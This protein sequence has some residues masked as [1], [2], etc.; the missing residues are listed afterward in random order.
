MAAA[1]SHEC[2]CG[3]AAAKVCKGCGR[4]WYCSK[5][6]Q[7]TDWPKH[8]V[9]CRAWKKMQKVSARRAS[10]ACMDLE[11]HP[12]FGLECV[13]CMDTCGPPYPIP[14]GCAC[15][16]IENKIG[17]HLDCLFKSAQAASGRL[18]GNAEPYH[19][20]SVCKKCFQG[21]AHEFL[22]VERAAVAKAAVEKQRTA[23]TVSEYESALY[24]LR[25]C[26]QYNPECSTYHS[27]AKTDLIG[28]AK[29]KGLSAGSLPH[30]IENANEKI[31]TGRGDEG[32]VELQAI[33]GDLI[34]LVERKGAPPESAAK[35]VQRF[36]QDHMTLLLLTRMSMI[37][38]LSGHESMMLAA[39]VR[40]DAIKAYGAEDEKTLSATTVWADSLLRAGMIEEAKI[41][42]VDHHRVLQR[43]MGKLHRD[44]QTVLKLL[45]RLGGSDPK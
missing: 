27:N 30:R 19:Q 7:M 23:E 2:V 10:G 45:C 28:A 41:A 21:A 16:A 12:N 36:Y 18:G 38:M 1:I 6:C 11:T 24:Q 35:Q 25:A 43:V 17:A 40:D 4:A 20:C 9:A 26:E 33:E 31:R 15:R 32:L 13:F 3:D 14:Q 37:P 44:T 5:E 34:W 22:A 42:L 8:K 29:S 39:K